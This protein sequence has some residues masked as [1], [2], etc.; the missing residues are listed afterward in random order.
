MSD[1]GTSGTGPTSPPSTTTPMDALF[2]AAVYLVDRQIA[3]GLGDRPALVGPRSTT[4]YD[5][6]AVQVAR[7]S[8]GWRALGVRP[9]E[10]VV[11]HAADTPDTVVA[12]LSLLRMG[13]VPVPVST[14]ST[15][16]ELTALLGD[17]RCRHLVAGAD[18]CERSQTAVWNVAAV[19]DL[20]GI[21]VLDDAPVEPPPGVVRVRWEHLLAAGEASGP[22]DRAPDRTT[23]DSPALWLYTSGTTGDPKAA[24]HRHGSIRYVAE[25][26]GEQVLELTPEDR[27]LSVA[28]LF[29][30]YG[31]GNSCFFPLAA[32]ATAVLDPAPPT[33]RSIARRLAEDTP[34]VFFGVPTSYAALLH[35]RRIPDDA[36]Q[37]VRLAVSAGEPLPPELQHRFRARFGVD[38]LNGMGSTEALHIFLSNRPGHCRPGSLGTPVPGYELRLTS[39]DGTESPPGEPGVLKVRAPSAAT[40]YWCRTAATHTVFQGPW[41]NTGD[42]FTREPDGEYVCHG[43]ANDMIKNGGIWVSPA[44]VEN[45]LLAH[46]TVAAVCVVAVPDADGLDRPVAC[47]VPASGDPVDAALD[48]AALTAFCRAALAPHKCP[49]QFLSFAS[50]PTTGTGKVNRHRVRQE[51]CARLQELGH[52]PRVPDQGSAP[53]EAP[54]PSVSPPGGD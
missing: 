46:P 48:P 40:G 12:L 19:P 39:A 16:R 27:C 54:A 28:K 13:A 53:L 14:M 23:E 32:G 33:P 21:V 8:A 51:A 2:N 9:E 29:F 26:Y 36:F 17:S 50:L 6:L 22:G 37:G 47:V 25:H 34:T 30:A 45:R 49:R 41:L 24:M 35:D 44:E 11:I 3:R 42:L 38:L 31:I 20:A 15:A 52:G 18:F 10:R 7:A 1:S 5:E 4:T 43:R